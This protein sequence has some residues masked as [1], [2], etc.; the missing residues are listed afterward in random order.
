MRAFSYAAATAAAAANMFANHQNLHHQHHHHQQKQQILRPTT[1][2]AMTLH[3]RHPQPT[4]SS[5][6]QPP[7]LNQHH[8]PHQHQQPQLFSI[9]P[10]DS[11]QII[12]DANG[13]GIASN[14]RRI[15]ESHKG[16]CLQNFIGMMSAL[17]RKI[18]IRYKSRGLLNVYATVAPSHKTRPSYLLIKLVW[19]LSTNVSGWS[20]EHY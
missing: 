13:Y 19:P 20:K 14:S 18:K 6:Q 11:A 1:T 4:S 9:T 8:H 12:R 16:K 3:N 5:G 17:I 15:T 10:T 2:Q 7:M